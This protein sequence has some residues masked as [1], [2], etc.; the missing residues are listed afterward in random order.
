MFFSCQTAYSPCSWNSDGMSPDIWLPSHSHPTGMLHVFSN[1]VYKYAQL[2][3][4]FPGSLNLCLAVALL[5]LMHNMSHQSQY[6]NFTFSSKDIRTDKFRTPIKLSPEDTVYAETIFKGNI[7]RIPRIHT[8]SF[9]RNLFYMSR[10]RAPRQ[11]VLL[12]LYSLAVL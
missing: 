11:G 1:N 4:L 3:K 6:V 10:R 5:V 7:V 2:K 9:R 8:I 12:S